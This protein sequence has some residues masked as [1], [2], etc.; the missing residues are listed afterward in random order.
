VTHSTKYGRQTARRSQGSQRPTVTAAERKAA[1]RG[2]RP[3][4]VLFESESHDALTG[5]YAA[6]RNKLDWNVKP[7]QVIETRGALT[8]IKCYHRDVDALRALLEAVPGV[9][10]R[11]TSGTLRALRRKA[12]LNGRAQRVL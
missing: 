3:R 4:Y 12:G 10:T 8:I 11:R 7:P 6:L 9:K 5:V 2:K 1:R